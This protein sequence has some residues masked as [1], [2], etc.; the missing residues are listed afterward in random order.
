MG[1]WNRERNEIERDKDARRDK[2]THSDT[3]QTTS[4]GWHISMLPEWGES[5]DVFHS[6]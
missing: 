2:E 4:C 3:K 1:Q 6:L 5:G